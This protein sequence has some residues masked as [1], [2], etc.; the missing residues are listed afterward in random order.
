MCLE[1]LIEIPRDAVTSALL[2]AIASSQQETRLLASENAQLRMR[3]SALGSP[4][5][6]STD[7]VSAAWRDLF[8]SLDSCPASSHRWHDTPAC[9]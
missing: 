6:L 1:M 5:G 3:L 2:Q 8:S 9:W 7:E 4:D